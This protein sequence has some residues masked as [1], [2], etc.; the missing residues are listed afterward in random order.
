[1]GGWS[2]FIISES[3][4]NMVTYLLAGRPTNLGLFPLRAKSFCFRLRRLQTL[5]GGVNQPRREAQQ[6]RLRV[7]L[8]R[9]K[10][11]FTY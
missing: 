1:M 9:R 4:V 2:L 11:K 8:L 7:M 10:D 6:L 3:S 5:A